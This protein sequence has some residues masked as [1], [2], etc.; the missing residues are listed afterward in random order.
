M[1]DF[2]AYIWIGIAIAIGIPLMG[3]F[4]WRMYT[5]WLIQRT[6]QRHLHFLS[7]YQVSAAFKHMIPRYIQVGAAKKKIAFHTYWRR[8]ILQPDDPFKAYWLMSPPGSGKTIAATRE[9]G[10]SQ[11]LAFRFPLKVVAFAGNT[12]DLAEKLSQVPQPDKCLIVIDGLDQHP[13]MQAD[14]RLFLDQLLIWTAPFAKRL[15]ISREDAIPGEVRA[16]KRGTISYTGES[17]FQLFAKLELL[18]IPGKSVAKN[19]QKRKGNGPKWARRIKS[20]TPLASLLGKQPAA[21]E[22]LTRL[23]FQNQSFRFVHQVYAA[24]WHR[25]MGRW[26]RK[27]QLNEDQLSQATEVMELVAQKIYRQ[28]RKGAGL[29]MDPAR[30]ALYLEEL[31]LENYPFYQQLWEV[32]AA[33]QLRWH[34]PRQWAFFLAWQYF[35]GK[36][37]LKLGELSWLPAVEDLFLGLHWEKFQRGFQ[38]HELS[39]R[40]LHEAGVKDLQELAPEEIRQLSRIYFLSPELGGKDFHMLKHLPALQ[41]IYLEAANR[42]ELPDGIWEALSRPDL[43]VYL[44]EGGEIKQVFQLEESDIALE[45]PGGNIYTTSAYEW[46]PVNLPEWLPLNKS[47]AGQDKPAMYK[48]V[49]IRKW[50]Q[51]RIDRFPLPMHPD[52]QLT[53]LPQ[54]IHEAR[55]VRFGRPELDLFNAGI[56]YR[57][58][59]MEHQVL[60]YHTHKPTI[61]LPVLQAITK[62]LVDLYGIDDR[63]KAYFGED[64]VAQV[65]DGFWPGRIW[66]WGNTDSYPFPIHLYMDEDRQVKLLIAGFPAP[67]HIKRES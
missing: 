32:N 54:G 47:Y 26:Q 31:E 10:L 9:I 35:H 46:K 50:F 44:R 66:A 28:A 55:E 17:Q 64:D 49:D 43:M 34:Q 3:L 8:Q 7:R 48:G 23:P 4:L 13:D 18:P 41:G 25:E 22:V 33:G 2:P 60:L 38:A 37:E 51:T 59:G 14:Y 27:Y 11:F 15:F 42:T 12:E 57:L 29:S 67:A 30:L 21:I 53:D 45:G 19:L 65:E 1:I 20:D 58:E 52:D 56:W 61:L 40:F 36:K 39:Y 5:P 24:E 6:Y 62:K 63:Q 16:G